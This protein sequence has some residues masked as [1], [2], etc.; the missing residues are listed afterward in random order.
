MTA[1]RH[2]SQVAD[3]DAISGHAT[4]S[5]ALWLEME[6]PSSSKTRMFA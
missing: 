1:T 3:K 6:S 4:L 5:E 2:L